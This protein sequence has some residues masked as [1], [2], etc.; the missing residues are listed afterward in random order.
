[1]AGLSVG[2]SVFAAASKWLDS[3]AVRDGT[4]YSYQPGQHSSN[5][6]TSGPHCSAASAWWS[7]ERDNPMLTGGMSY[8]MNHLPEN[9]LPNVYYW[10]CAARRLRRTRN[11]RL[12]GH[13]E[14]QDV[15]FAGSHPGSYDRRLC[16]R[17]LVAGE[18]RLGQEWRSS[19]DDQPFRPDVGNQ[20]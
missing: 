9:R 17:Q 5:T 13:L 14:P 2:G 6:M 7:S 20:H 18:G 11:G 19:H 1:M 16:Q 12:V 10:S 15:R 8:L 3:V 4:E